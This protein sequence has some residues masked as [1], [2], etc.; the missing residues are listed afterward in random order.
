MKQS[1]TFCIRTMPPADLKCG[2]SVPAPPQEKFNLF[3]LSHRGFKFS[4]ST[5][6]KKAVG[7][8]Q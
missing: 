8:K 6:A 7:Q 2:K 3:L 1:H 5:I 4:P